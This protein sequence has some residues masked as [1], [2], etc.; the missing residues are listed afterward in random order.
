[1]FGKGMGN[2]YKQAHQLQK[3]LNNVQEELK[4]LE[5]E[6][7]SGGEMVKVVVNGKKDIISINIQE[8]ILKEDKDMVE[9]MVLAAVKKAMSNAEK[10]AEKKMKA[11]TGGMMP[12]MNMPG[13]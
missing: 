6:G 5:I 9:D 12:N 11:V 1:M 13:F 8:D 10:I 7:S 4:S 3:N 2:L